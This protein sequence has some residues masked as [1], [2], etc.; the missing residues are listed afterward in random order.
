MAQLLEHLQI[1]EGDQRTG[2]HRS[3]RREFCPIPPRA[4]WFEGRLTAFFPSHATTNGAHT[5][6]D[7]RCRSLLARLDWNLRSSQSCPFCGGF[8]D[9]NSYSSALDCALPG[10]KDPERMILSIT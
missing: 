7:T 1:Q 8:N 2:R 3:P 10:A 4:G 5:V 6:R 9:A